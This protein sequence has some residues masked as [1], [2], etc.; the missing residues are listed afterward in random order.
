MKKNDY[1][2]DFKFDWVIK[3]ATKGEYTPAPV[4]DYKQQLRQ[5]LEYQKDNTGPGGEQKGMDV[6][7][8]DED[9]EDDQ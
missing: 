2:V 4:E 8:N 3:K 6:D 9:E 5:K 1:E 7:D